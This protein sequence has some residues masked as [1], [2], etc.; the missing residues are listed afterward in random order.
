MTDRITR[1]IEVAVDAE[2][3][4]FVGLAAPFN[5]TI[6]FDGNLERYAPGVLKDA[7]PVKVYY[8]HLDASAEPVGVVE[9]YNETEVGV[10]VTVRFLESDYA[11]TIRRRM[12]DCEITGLSL[13]GVVRDAH[14]EDGV[15]VYDAI[16]L[17]EVSI[18][19]RPAY[20]TARVSVVRAE[21]KTSEATSEHI[22][23]KEVSAKDTQSM[24]NEIYDDS[25]LRSEVADLKRSI[26][27]LANKE[28]V[29]E[30]PHSTIKSLGEF[31][32]RYADGDDEAHNLRRAYS[33]G[34][35]A[36]S[37]FANGWT[38]DIIKIVNH[39]RPVWNAFSKGQWVEEGNNI[40]YAKLDTNTIVVG[41]QANEG[42]TLPFG[43]VSVTTAYVAKQVRGGYTEMSVQEIKRSNVNILSVAFEAMA[44]E[45]ARATE[46]DVRAALAGAAAQTVTG[47]LADADGWANFIVDASV[48]LDGKGLAPEFLI[49]SQDKYKQLVT[50]SKTDPYVLSRNSGSVNVTGLSGEVLSLPLLVMPGTGIATVA[51]SSAIKTFEAPGAPFN[52]QD[53]NI[54]NLTKQFS[55]W[56]EDAVA[57]QDAKALVKVA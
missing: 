15:T 27:V 40:E 9:A 28:E 30:A 44:A 57:V 8:N 34:T 14:D 18:V 41:S 5:E 23:E 36:D 49:V 22:N 52:L 19:D 2:A 31:V 24:T 12:A 53:E 10:E 29:V 56:G 13:Q 38:N 33:G 6:E 3:G 17:F 39:G 47:S 51:H 7:L 42:D 16:E 50:L 37:V 26:E 4:T 32:K 45:Y 35:T 55:I 21:E 25:E 48:H 11:Q 43:K 46:A 54:L 1:T 20:D